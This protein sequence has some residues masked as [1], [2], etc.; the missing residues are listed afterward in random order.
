MKWTTVE[1]TSDT[2][3]EYAEVSGGRLYRA[4]VYRSSWDRT[5][6]REVE[7]TLSQSIAFVPD[8]ERAT[9]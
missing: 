9:S 1:E 5:T 2:R 3:L 7:E 6:Q 4:T 8:P